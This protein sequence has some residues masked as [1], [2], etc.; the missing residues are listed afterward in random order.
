M[1]SSAVPGTDP[2][3]TGGQADTKAPLLSSRNSARSPRKQEEKV[4]HDNAGEPAVAANPALKSNLMEITNL[5]LQDR[6]KDVSQRT[7]QFASEIERLKTEA[8]I[9]ESEAIA[10]YQHLQNELVRK[11][12]TNKAL[13][14]HIQELTQM[15]IADKQA[16]KELIERTL[17]QAEQI[18]LEKEKKLLAK[19]QELVAEL[20]DLKQFQRIRADL[21]AELEATKAMMAANEARHQAQLENLERRFNLARER[22]EKEAAIRI[23]H[24]RETY[25]EEISRELDVESRFIRT[26]NL[27][28]AKELKFHEMTSQQF[29]KTAQELR[30]ELARVKLDAELQGQ[31][32]EALARQSWKLKQENEQLTATVKSLEHALSSTTRDAALEQ[33]TWKAHAQRRIEQLEQELAETKRLL[34]E[35]THELKTIRVH[36]QNLLA[37]RSELE[38]FFADALAQVR[39]EIQAKQ[40]LERANAIKQRD[41]MVRDL[42]LGN[43][44]SLKYEDITRLPPVPEPP[45]SKHLDVRDLTPEQRYEIIRLM[46]ARIRNSKMRIRNS[47]MAAYAS[48]QRGTP[49]SVDQLQNGNPAAPELKQDILPMLTSSPSN[50]HASRPISAGRRA[51]RPA[52]RGPALTWI[53]SSPA[54]P[55]PATPSTTAPTPVTHASDDQE[56][57]HPPSN[58]VSQGAS[59][60][61]SSF[62]ITAGHIED[63]QDSY[64]VRDEGDSDFNN[65]PFERIKS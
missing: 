59:G 63:E 4:A 53:N 60:S 7:Y 35:R 13:T 48:S 3:N 58:R 32:H 47:K 29:Q 40:A 14:K 17:K 27:R 11:E 8:N 45:A 64:I 9:A 61:G 21:L 15:Q 20:A 46:F 5:A 31:R 23:A 30:Q 19:Q 10:R 18:F 42:A 33:A 55:Q 41:R 56:S 57:G 50:E 24:S 51:G 6:L 34:S 2:G 25:K 49:G 62:F 36:A 22:L 16:M 44:A 43:S 26:E 65:R 52:S 38:T 1:S 28:L 12:Q 39:Q 54:F 37:S